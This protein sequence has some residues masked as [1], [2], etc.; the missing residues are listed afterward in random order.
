MLRELQIEDIGIIERLDMEFQKGLNVLTG[1]TGA[2]KSIIIASFSL[3]LGERIKP[4]EMIRKGAE[5]GKVT[6]LFELPEKSPMISWLVGIGIPVSDGEVLIRREVSLNGKNR[7]L[8]NG[9]VVTVAQLKE[10][11]DMVVDIHGTHDHQKLLNPS[12]HLFYLDRY[13]GTEK[14]LLDY[15]EAFELWSSKKRELE[16]IAR[17]QGQLKDRLEF[18]SYQL[19][20]LEYVEKIGETEEDIEREHAILSDSSRLKELCEQALTLGCDGKESILSSLKAFKT[21]IK[22]LAAVEPAFSEELEELESASITVSETS[23]R[24]SEF[25][26]S[27]SPNPGRL[28]ELE[29][30]LSNLKRHELKYGSD[31]KG[32]KKLYGDLKHQIESIQNPADTEVLRGEIRKYE[33]SM[34]DLSRVLTAKRK[35]SAKA[36]ELAFKKELSDLGMPYSQVMVHLGK[37]EPSRDGMDEVE[38]MLLSNP[39]ETEKP[40]SK[41]AS[42]GELCRIMLAFKTILAKT[43][44]IAILVFDEIDANIGGV[45]AVAAGEKMLAVSESRQ[46][47]TITH[48]PQIASKALRHFSVSKLQTKE[49]TKT[50]LKLLDFDD[51]VEEIARML[52]GS[53]ITSVV[54]DHAREMLGGMKEAKDLEKIPSTKSPKETKKKESH[55]ISG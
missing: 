11:G 53:G 54:R 55:R 39:G 44:N 19:K 41:I 3:L 17:N 28:E 42:G 35:K 43:D 40:L 38:F 18:L 6:G 32:L 45:T 51:R 9:E 47:I 26:N 36:L 10:F 48:Q 8:I 52:G 31:L 24:I 30:L 13:S 5:S 7:C 16:E 34:T 49:R 29:S 12:T 20:E 33:A 14:E 23:N 50:E 46:V 22:E 15:Q 37:K 21:I 1:E 27:V 4:A 2:G 25:G